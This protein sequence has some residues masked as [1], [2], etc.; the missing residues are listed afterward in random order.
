MEAPVVIKAGSKLIYRN[1]DDAPYTIYAFGFYG[2]TESYP[3][4]VSALATTVGDAAPALR[5]GL[6]LVLGALLLYTYRV[7]Q[8]E[9]TQETG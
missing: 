4:A 3:T 2:S 5:L 7:V 8:R 1:L 6:L 9:S